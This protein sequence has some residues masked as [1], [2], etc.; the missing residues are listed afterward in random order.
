MRKVIPEDLYNFKFVHDP[1]ISPDGKHILFTVTQPKGPNDYTSTIWKY[2]S[3]QTVAVIS[4]KDRVFSPVFSKGGDLFV[5]LSTGAGSHELWVSDLLGKSNARVLSLEGRK[6][7]S[8]RWSQDEKAIFFLSN[9]DPSCPKEPKTDVRLITRMN[10]RFD[11]EGYLH[12]RRT[13]IFEISLED[14]QLRQV[15]KGEFDVAA[16]DLSPDGK[17]VAFVSNL[18]SDADF[19]NNLDIHS[20]PTSGDGEISK[21]TNNRGSMSSLS[22]SPDGKYI[23]FIGDDYRDKFN[24][25]VQ[26][27]VHDLENHR[28]FCASAKLDRQTRN[29]ILSDAI[30][31]SSTAEPV[32]SA[33]SSTLYFSATDQGR[34]NI[35]CAKIE[36]TEISEITY[37]NQVVT[38]FSVSHNGKIAFTKMDPTHPAELFLLKPDDNLQHLSSFSARLLSEIALSEVQEFHFPA[39]DGMEIHGFFMQPIGKKNGEK[40]PCIVEIHGGGSTEGYQFMVEFQSLTALG[41]SVATCNFRGTAGYGEDFMKVL[42]GHYMEKD[43]SDVIDMVNYLV[44]KGWIDEKRIGVTG[45]SYGGYLTNWAISHSQLFKAAVTDRSVVNLYSFYGTSDDYRLIEEDV[46]ESFP[47]DRPESYLAKSPIAYTKAVTT[48]LLILHSEEDFRCRLEQAEQL[49]AFLKRQGKVVVFA[50]FPGESHGLSRGG[51]P[52]HR[53]ERLQLMLWWFTS[54]IPTG[55]NPVQCPI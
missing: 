24:T 8:P 33:D 13:H 31:N 3:E 49:Y 32:W 28:T 34:C 38:G 1:T 4:G 21:L 9:Y 6:I 43:Y 22:Y 47:W 5:Y 14:K 53:V 15:T 51:K 41:Y 11:G 54:H 10:Y 17:K 40:P 26:V 42:T 18:D 16:F 30:M 48:P 12:D 50:I 39:R 23:A 45:G 55:E 27:W 19:Q 29:S 52:H 36:S 44:D 20:V 37:G 35:F 2:S 7:S 25:P 46:Q